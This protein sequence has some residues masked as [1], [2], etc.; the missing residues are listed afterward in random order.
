MALAQ[1][2]TLS[3][4]KNDTV[5]N[6]M[7]QIQSYQDQGRLQLPPGYSAQNA[8]MSAWLVLQAVQ[9]KDHRPALQVCTKDSIANALLDMVVQGLNPAK[10]QC[11]FIVYGSQ[12][13]CQ[14]SYFGTRTVTKRVTGCKDIFA[15]VVYEGDTFKYKIVGGNKVILEHT[16]DLANVD[17]RKIKAAYCIVVPA[18]GEPHTE[19][20]TM[21]QIKQ[22]WMQSR[23]SPFDEQGN[24]KPGSVHAKFSEEMAKKTVTNRTCKMFI[25]SS[26]DDSLIVERINRSDD[27]AEEAEFEE[28]VK[29]SAN[30]EVLDAEYVEKTTDAE[31]AQE[32][33]GEPEHEEVTHGPE[34]EKEPDPAPKQP[35]P[36]AT[37]GRRSRPQL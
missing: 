33:Q 21:D 34:T 26:N 1:E 4:I 23:Q 20:M 8:L 3:L 29:Q 14:R 12:L 18:E 22:A 2:K 25:N 6:A 15:E 31:P 36:P 35:A 28:E 9:D 16:Q 24:L 19:I 5:T 32:E 13:F 27:E 30:G 11:Y 7:S 37:T 10:K 17:K